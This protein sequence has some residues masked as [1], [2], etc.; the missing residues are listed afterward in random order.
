[1]YVPPVV[2]DELK[3]ISREDDLLFG[4]EAF[5]KMVKYTRVGREANRLCDFAYPWDKKV[6]LP[7]VD[8]YPTRGRKKKN[9]VGSPF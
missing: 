9:F 8:A 2:I 3:D 6:S 5:R 7:D 4:A 1:M